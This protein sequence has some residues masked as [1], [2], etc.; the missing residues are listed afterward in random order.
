MTFRRL[1]GSATRG[2][3]LAEV[4][5]GLAL[6]G[7]VLFLV[8]RLLSVA[9]ETSARES[10]LIEMEQTALVALQRIEKELQKTTAGGVSYLSKQ[11]NQDSGVAVNPID[12]VSAD[13]N[14]AWVDRVVIFHWSPGEK[15]LRRTS[16]LGLSATSLSLP[17]HLTE[18]QIRSL[19]GRPD[20]A[21]GIIGNGVSDF[22]VQPGVAVGSSPVVL[23]S[24][25][26]E[27]RFPR[28]GLRHF[29]MTRQVTLRN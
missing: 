18:V 19:L 12:D 4:L 28:Q 23:V 2:L 21:T 5:I 10:A 29:A 20:R 26:L 22:D 8:A 11:A 17:V 6:V 16:V 15:L 3:S 7:V 13:G 24:V 25:E 9:L 1:H 14:L 27:R